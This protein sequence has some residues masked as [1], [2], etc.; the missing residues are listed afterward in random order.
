MCYWK[1]WR[2]PRTR[3]ANLLKLGTSKRHAIGKPDFTVE[4]HADCLK[5]LDAKKLGTEQV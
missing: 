3:I 5:P 4:S 2:R 1:Q